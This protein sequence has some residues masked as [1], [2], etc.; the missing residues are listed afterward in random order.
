MFRMFERE[1]GIVGFFAD[2]FKLLDAAKKTYASGYRK[3][4][5]I[6]PFAIHGMDEAMGLERST[7]PW[8]SFTFGVLGCAFAVF[9]QWYTSA[10]SWPII[11]GGKPM[12]SLPAFIPIIF[13]FT[14]LSCG[15]ATF[16]AVLF[17][18]KL[19]KVDPPLIDPDLT[20]HKFAVF[21]PS[22]DVGFEKSKA[23]DFLKSIGA[24]DIRDVAEY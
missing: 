19:P 14:V 23:K 7:L 4:D 5:T 15:L 17:Y 24:V 10:Y 3:Y 20:C 12:F 9:I 18:C 6:S 2:E 8:V 22:G 16:G 21:I 1:S 11:V 13:E